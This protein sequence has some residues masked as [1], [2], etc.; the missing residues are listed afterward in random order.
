MGS[1]G[2]T[3]VKTANGT[4]NFDT[5]TIS[6]ANNLTISS[7]GGAISINAVRGSGT[8]TS[9]TVNADGNTT[10]TEK[11]SIGL[12]GSGNEIGA[13]TCLLYTSPSP[14]DLH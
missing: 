7:A 5:G 3:T 13:V 11:I 2:A 10:A 14:R 1:A 12:I 9:L 4:I 8:A 6:K